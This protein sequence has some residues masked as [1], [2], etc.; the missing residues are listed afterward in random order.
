MAK[1]VVALVFIF[2]AVSMAWATL[3]GS[4]SQRTRQQEGKLSNEVADLWGEPQQQLSPELV[5]TWPVRKEEQKKEKDE[6]TGKVTIVTKEIITWERKPVSLGS[7]E[8]AA[9]LKLEYRRRGL[10]WH[11]LY[12]VAFRGDYAYTH[13]EPQSGWLIV[14]YRF[15]T[16]AGIY[17]DFQFEVD[18]RPFDRAVATGPS[19]AGAAPGVAPDHRGGVARAGADDAAPRPAFGDWLEQRV[20]VTPGKPVAFT[21]AYKS[22]GLNVWRYSFGNDINQVKNFHLTMTTDFNDIDFPGGSLSPTLK[23]KQANGWK[24]DWQFKNIVAAVKVG[25]TMPAK[26]N[27]GPLAAQ[28]SFFAP[29]C[30]GF[31]FVWLFVITL[32]RKIDLHPINYLFLGAAFFAFHLL[33]A[34]LADHLDVLASFAVSSAVS[35]FLVVSYL[36]LAAGL[37]FAAV[38]AGLSQLLYLVFFSYAHFIEGYTGLIVTIGSIVTLFAIM[39]LT[40]RIK[41]SEKFANGVAPRPIPAAQP[42]AK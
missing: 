33:F 30:L 1:R 37:R 11:S 6:K 23:T 18:G 19:A 27:P 12:T 14:T 32:L 3:G 40:G 8:L 2:V 5:F 41:W 38:E 21:V 39:Q 16:P 31:F 10:L 34:Y 28:I 26:L 29:V 13:D 7:S 24:L 4:V 35:V 20:P 42:A 25:M 9:D 36:R 22:R 15:P 17:D